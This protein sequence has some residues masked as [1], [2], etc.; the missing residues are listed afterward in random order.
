MQKTSNKIVFFGSGPVAARSLELLSKYCIVEAVITKPRAPGH[1]GDVPVI[2]VATSLDLPF[3]TTNSRQELDVLVQK[4]K[5]T[6]RL[7]ILIDFGIIVSPQII[8]SFPLGIINSHFSLLPQWRGADPIT[9]SILSGQKETG[10]SLMLLT[11]G[12][13]EGPILAYA[14]YELAPD[15]TTPLLTAELI[16]VSDGLLREIIPLYLAGAIAAQPQNENEPP[17]YSRKL[18]KEDGRINWH[19]HAAVIEREIRAFVEWPKSYSTIA[20]VA[21]II[22]KA[23]LSSLAG[24]P[25][26]FA[27]INKELVAFC[28]T[29]ALVID[30]LKPAGKREMQAKA[31]IAGYG[32]K[33]NP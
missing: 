4:Q 8:H 31:F 12:M 11:A 20:G 2:E 6:S 33:L 29:G 1:H 5:F 32:K 14:P 23:H 25:G 17:S 21:V 18:T 16:N 26:S 10:V 7:G 28:G 3:F 24:P 27:I 13:D 30:A 22:T 19:K 15:I 9:F